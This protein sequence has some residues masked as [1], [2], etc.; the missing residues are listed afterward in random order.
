MVV[1]CVG[2]GE[3]TRGQQKCPRPQEAAQEL[4][5]RYDEN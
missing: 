4:L 1:T 3:P 5:K 2:S